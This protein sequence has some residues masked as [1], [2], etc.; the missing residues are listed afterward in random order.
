MHIITYR[1]A[2]PAIEPRASA[3]SC[4][5]IGCSFTSLRTLESASEA[6]LFCNWP[7][8]YATWTRSKIKKIQ[9]NYT[10]GEQNQSYPKQER[11][12]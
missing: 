8:T 1:E 3:A 6:F 7:K 2:E 10:Q 9:R 5:T 4:L 12:I 11:P